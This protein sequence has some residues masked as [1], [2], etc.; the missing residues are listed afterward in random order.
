M[1]DNLTLIHNKLFPLW[2]IIII[3]GLKDTAHGA[4]NQIGSTINSYCIRF[5]LLIEIG[6]EIK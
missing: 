5:V 4:M 1:E 2:T 3:Y 6:D